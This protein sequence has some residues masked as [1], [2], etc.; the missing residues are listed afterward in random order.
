M[1]T[2]TTGAWI[3]DPNAYRRKLAERLGDRDPMTV[4]SETADILADI[5][6][7]HTPGQLRTR[8]FEGKWTPNE[9]IGHLTD[10]EWTYGY[11]MRLIL[12]EDE[13]AIIGTDQDRWVTAQRFNEREA[14]ELVEMFRS[15]RELN[16]ATW[17]NVT[18]GEMTRKGLHNQ[19]GEESLAQMFRM[20]A[21]HDLAHIDQIN[22]Y[23]EAIQR[24]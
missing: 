4:M 11:R 19:R 24:D 21:G 2:A 16:L 12:S 1:T 8:P 6:A 22:R 3:T 13:P 23:L 15:L 17:K 9:V 14:A 7:R 10:G 20:L 5:V 18:P